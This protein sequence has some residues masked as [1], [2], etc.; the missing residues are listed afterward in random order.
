MKALVLAAF[1]AA[2]LLSQ[3]AVAQTACP[4]AA[5][6]ARGI[7]IDFA[8]GGSE[9]YRS[10]ATPGV[11]DVT[12][13]DPDG[14]TYMMQLAG[15]F[16]LLRWEVPGDVSSVIAYDYG[17]PPAQMPLPQPGASWYTEVHVTAA[18]GPREEPQ[19]HRYGKTTQVTIGGC[20]YTAVEAVIAYATSDNYVESV[21]WLPELGLGYLLWNESTD[22]T[23]S[24]VPATGISA[25]K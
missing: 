2:V 25:G 9:T 8:D 6:L 11:V 15:G 13:H 23:R 4:V 22:Y 14:S 16:H 20:T 5:D 19:D 24:P 17:L 21:T 1:S 7:R 10:A 3:A 18:E 12:G